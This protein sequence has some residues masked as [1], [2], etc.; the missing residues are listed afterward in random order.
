MCKD[1]ALPLHG[2]C[3]IEMLDETGCCVGIECPQGFGCNS[4]KPAPSTGLSSKSNNISVFGNVSM[5]TAIA[6]KVNVSPDVPSASAKTN[7]FLC[8][9]STLKPNKPRTVLIDGKPHQLPVIPSAATEGGTPQAEPRF[10]DTT[11]SSVKDIARSSLLLMGNKKSFWWMCYSSVDPPPKPSDGNYCNICGKHVSL[12]ISV[13]PTNLGRHVRGAH[14]EVY[15]LVKA[16][17][18]V[19]QLEKKQVQPSINEFTRTKVPS[20]EIR[21]Q[22]LRA[23]TMAIVSMGVPQR[24]V[25]NQQARLWIRFCER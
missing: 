7:L 9:N 8:R 3:G 14:P 19:A 13:T 5:V 4:S 24:T 25:L 10:V 21:Q 18:K 2:G 16:S 17:N 6:S 20:K 15:A 23:T 12:G 22:C 11:H 1:C